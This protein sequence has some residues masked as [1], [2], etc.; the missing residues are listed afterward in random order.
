[1]GDIYGPL[2]MSGMEKSP[3][4]TK[5]DHLRYLNCLFLRRLYKV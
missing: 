4:T 5:P 1:M 2:V 3:W